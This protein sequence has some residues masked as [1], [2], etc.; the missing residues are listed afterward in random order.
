M[1]N[2]YSLSVSIVTELHDFKNSLDRVQLPE[3]AAR[4]FFQ[5]LAEESECVCGRV[6]DENIKNRIIDAA[7]I[8]STDTILEIGPGFGALTEKL[9]EKE[10]TIYAVEKDSDEFFDI[11]KN[12]IP[13]DFVVFTACRGR[14]GFQRGAIL[15]GESL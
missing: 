10:A 14:Q 11:L 12:N 15:S 4:E 7:K 13:V 1:T 9:L 2:P 3:T 5:E 8:T 6:I